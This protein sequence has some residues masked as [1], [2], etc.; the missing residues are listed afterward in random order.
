MK[1]SILIVDDETL[2]LESLKKALSREGYVALTATTGREALRCFEEHGPDLVLLDVKLPDIDG[3]QVLQRLRKVDTQTPII[4]MTAYSGIK[5]AVEAI[6]FGAYDYIAKPFDVDELKFVVARSLASR[7]VEAEVDQIRTTKKERYSFANILTVNERM[8]QIIKLGQRVANNSQSTVLISGESGTGKELF[9]NAIHY[10]GPRADQ[11]LVAINC[12]VLSEGVLESELFG[13][14]K[15]AFTGAIK[16]KKGLFEL[17]DQ[18]TLFLDEIGEISP[19]TQLKLLRFLEERE[20]QR[21]G[22]TRSI[23][24]DVRIITATNKNLRQNVEDGK[25]REDLYYRLNVISL[26][27]PPLRERQDDIPLLADYF[28]EKYSRLLSKNVRRLSEEARGVLLRYPWPG[29]VRELKNII[30]R[31]VLLSDDDVIAG[32]EIPAEIGGPPHKTDL[33]KAGL[34]EEMPLDKLIKLYTEGILARCGGN[35]TR[36]AEILGI[37]RQR[38]RRILKSQA[39]GESDPDSGPI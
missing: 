22:G 32:R 5:G 20:F 21:V 1:S 8:K 7:R 3:I 11:P 24:V 27:I 10:N 29:N 35:R 9:A 12:A 38:L 17:A 4:I 28:L 33:F 36:T 23:E 2:L 14:E 30:E 25:F 16:Q 15:G 31:I 34:V 26:P 18:G 39:P 19:A 37:T 13:H 6:K